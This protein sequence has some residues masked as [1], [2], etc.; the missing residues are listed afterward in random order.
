MSEV[1]LNLLNLCISECLMYSSIFSPKNYH[2]NV[3]W[4]V[5]WAVTIW[6]HCLCNKT[7]KQIRF[8]LFFLFS[9]L[10]IF[11]FYAQYVLFVCTVYPFLLL[12]CLLNSF[13]SKG[14]PLIMPSGWTPMRRIT[15]MAYGGQES[16]I[17]RWGSGQ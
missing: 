1:T 2:N 7:G 8:V 11:D 17:G 6:N 3:F 16:V 13:P 4:N 12:F 5:S 15:P 9:W 14:K 10:L